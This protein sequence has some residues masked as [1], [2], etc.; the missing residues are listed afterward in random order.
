V[1]LE[2]AGGQLNF[3]VYEPWGAVRERKRHSVQLFTLLNVRD[4][5]LDELAVRRAQLELDL[6]LTGRRANQLTGHEQYADEPD[7]ASDALFVGFEPGE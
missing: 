5:H 3:V 1:H 4:P 7:H 6:H 2:V